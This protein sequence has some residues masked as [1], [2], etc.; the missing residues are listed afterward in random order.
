[1]KIASSSI[2]NQKTDV[3]K[4]YLSIMN[5]LKKIT[6]VLS[7]RVRFG[8]C[9]DGKRGENL[10]GIF[11]EFTSHANVDTEFAVEHGFATVIPVGRIIIWQDKAGSLYQDPTVGTDWTI[12]NAYFKCDAAAVKFL[13]FFLK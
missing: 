12:T 6:D 13:V 4:L 7:G 2:R 8:S 9:L 1:M 5:D 11:K 10:D 3:R